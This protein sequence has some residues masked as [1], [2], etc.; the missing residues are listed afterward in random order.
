MKESRFERKFTDMIKLYGGKSL[1]WVSPGTAGVPDRLAFLPGGL[2]LVAEIKKP[3]TGKL[4]ALQEAMIG[5]LRELGFW[6]EVVDSE[7]KLNEI[8]ET[9]KVIL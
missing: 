9:L 6:V 5:M 1:K 8:D 2:L 7:E 3:G 4:S